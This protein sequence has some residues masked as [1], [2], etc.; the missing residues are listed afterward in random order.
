MEQHVQDMIN[1]LRIQEEHERYLNYLLKNYTPK[2]L[3]VVT[4]KKNKLVKLEELIKLRLFTLH[5]EVFMY[6]IFG[7][8]PYI[9]NPSGIYFTTETLTNFFET[10]KIK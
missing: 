2:P 6:I 5:E 10:F 8:L 7:F 3:Q 4:K 1:A 9:S